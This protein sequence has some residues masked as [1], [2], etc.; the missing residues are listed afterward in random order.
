[1]C[2]QVSTR[3]LARWITISWMKN[4]I[5]FLGAWLSATPAFAAE[6]NYALVALAPDNTLVLFTS[7]NPKAT[8]IV[9]LSGVSSPLLGLDVRPVDLKLYGIT[10]TDQLVTI[11]LPSGVATVTSTLATPSAA[12]TA[13]GFDFNPQADRLRLIGTDGSN[14]RVS[15]GVGAVA[16]D[17][18]LAYAPG[19]RAAGK[20][21]RVTAVAYTNSF[22]N[23][24]TTITF[25]LDTEADTLVRQ[26]PPNE[27]I[28]HTVGPLGVDCGDATGFDI[29]SPSP[30]VDDAFVICGRTLYR[31]NLATGR[32]SVIGEVQAA[33]PHL[34]SLAVLPSGT[35]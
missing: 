13:S 6:R 3:G 1:M 4:I 16:T 9:K 31:A 5:F 10:A 33:V 18:K 15:V 26:E 29:V 23:A 24:P 27:G 19:D 35:R 8:R 2:L 32:L 17:G 34:F 30:G 11:E 28:L 14:L 20:S 7:D 22:A 12:T 25:D 21:P